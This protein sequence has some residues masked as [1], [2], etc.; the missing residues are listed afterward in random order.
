MHRTI[1]IAVP[2]R[3]TQGILKEIEKNE[4]V[5]NI[6]VNE[7]A[8]I[9]P[10]GDSLTIHVL[11]K[12]ADE[13]LKTIERHSKEV[14]Y[15]VITTEAAS[16]NDPV[17]QKQI[18]QDVDEAI[19]EELETGLR[20][21]GRFTENFGI[22]MFVGG[23]IGAVSMVSNMPDLVVAFIA[24]SIIAPGLEPVAKIPLGI[25]LKK[26]EV[27]FAGLKATVIGYGLLITASALSFW[28]MFEFGSITKETFFD[29]KATQSLMKFQTQHFLL[30]LAASVAS[31]TMYLSYRRN[32]IA[33]PLIALIF[34]P[35]T[36][37]V[38]IALF[39][40]EWSFAFLFLKRF[41]IDIGIFI[42]VGLVLM[43]YKQL[44][45]HKRE[46]IR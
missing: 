29:N 2:S 30:S 16:F 11:N 40:H 38:G 25:I 27:F 9:K 12:G 33:G 14:E 42:S 18:D 23:I 7:D 19:W 6:V 5:I 4:H 15:T 45:V 17:K 24:A 22:L 32:V 43:T 13:V 26:K 34:I 31:I 20:H 44:K 39:L 8:S 36:A 3:I 37:A 10:K 35:A 41:L 28:V 1:E 21:N 46:P